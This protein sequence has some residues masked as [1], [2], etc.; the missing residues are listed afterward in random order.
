VGHFVAKTDA[1]Y[2][3]RRA[4][5]RVVE[6]VLSGAVT[7]DPVLERTEIDQSCP[8]CGASVEV[9]YAQ[10]RLVS[11]CTECEGSYAGSSASGVQSTRNE[12]GYLGYEPLPPAGLDERSPTEVRRA[13][14]TWNMS[15]RL[16]AASGVCPRC[17]AALGETV[18][19]C[20]DHDDDGRCS[21]CGHRHAVRHTADCTNC[22][23]RQGGAFVLALLADTELL[24]FLTD[25]GINPVAPTAHSAP[26]FTEVV[27][28]YDEELVSVDPLEARFT[29]V[30]DGDALTLTVDDDLDVVATERHDAA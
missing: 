16:P 29:F 19:T 7:D 4:G 1:G 21:T 28:D 26:R 3:L 17:S 14:H 22:I 2:E 30:V 5:E 8:Y 24:S 13:A 10:E 11:Y 27:M 9:R 6:A 15:E 18:E 23:F 12:R 20:D 25:H